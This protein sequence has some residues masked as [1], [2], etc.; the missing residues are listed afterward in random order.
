MA[1]AEIEYD[2]LKTI[3]LGIDDIKL[4][5]KR[6]RSEV[7]EKLKKNLMGLCDKSELKE[8]SQKLKDFVKAQNQELKNLILDKI[9]VF[10]NNL[11]LKI[12]LFYF[13]KNPTVFL[14]IKCSH[15]KTI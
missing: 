9:K 6:V 3:D 7:K 10:V 8:L 14:K 4:H 1:Y 13:R 5:G 11:F 15:L 12:I 2:R